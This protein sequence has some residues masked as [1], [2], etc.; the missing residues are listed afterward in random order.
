MTNTQ[1]A[2]KAQAYKELQ[3]EIKTLEAQLDALKQELIAEMDEKHA[4]KLQAGAFTV[5]YTVYA[6]ER[7]DGKKLKAEQ[8]ELYAG[9]VRQVTACRFQV[10]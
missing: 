10:A 2:A 4:E 7:L 5:N 8:P 9:Y 6:S 1:L 3:N